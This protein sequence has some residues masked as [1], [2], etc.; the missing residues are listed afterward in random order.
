M[1]VGLHVQYRS[2]LLSDLNETSIFSAECRK[3][4]IIFHENTSSGSGILPC[5]RTDGQTDRHDEAISRFCNFANAPK[6]PYSPLPQ[7]IY[8]NVLS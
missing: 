6:N 3:I 7:R 5:R 2:L 1:Y 8:G 4:H